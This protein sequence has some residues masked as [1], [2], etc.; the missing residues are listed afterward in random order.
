MIHLVWC[1]FADFFQF[2]EELSKVPCLI[3]VIGEEH[4]CYIGSVGGR[5]GKGGL[6]VRYEPQYINRAKA[7]F[8]QDKPAHQPAFA[9]ITCDTGIP[10]DKIEHIE[11][12]VQE[13]FLNAV[14]PQSALF[15]TRGKPPGI[16]IVHEG[17]TPGFLRPGLNKPLQPT[18]PTAG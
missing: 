6:G 3:Y 10:V 5:G 1:R 18:S 2:Y 16:A 7:I 15:T 8:G 17:D 11:R 9:A 13:S 12:Q 14:G 4:H